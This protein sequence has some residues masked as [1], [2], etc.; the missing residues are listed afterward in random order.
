MNIFSH[1]IGISLISAKK[2]YA[3]PKAESKEL[4]DN[5]DGIEK[6]S[7]SRSTFSFSQ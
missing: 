7:H 6:V 4:A 3:L 5:I 2:T 1:V